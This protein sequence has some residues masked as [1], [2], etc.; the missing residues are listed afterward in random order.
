MSYDEG[1]YSTDAVRQW[2]LGAF[3]VQRKHGDE[4]QFECPACAHP[5][6]YWNCKKAVGYCHRASCRETYN[7]DKMIERVG[8][9]PDQHAYSAKVAPPRI[10]SEVRLPAGATPVARNADAVIALATRGVTWD[11]IVQFGIL[12][13]DK[14][15]YVPITEGGEL[16]QYNSRKIDKS[17]A[18]K[19]WFDAGPNPYLYG[20][21]HPVTHYFLG[22]DECKLWPDI[23]LVENTFVSMWLRDL[24]C[25]ATFGSH[26]SDTHINKILH[27]NIKHVTFLWDNGT[28]FASQKAQRKLKALGIGSSVIHILDQP[29]DLTKEEIKEMLHERHN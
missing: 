7:L 6:F 5:S 27:S 26:L 9:P 11:H 13:D 29:D 28:A 16:K 18:P 22:W 24:H 1:K 3:A 8:H 20:K 10:I 17:K 15:L 12:E 19:D 2:I 14:R 23:V 21:G 25:T 4:L